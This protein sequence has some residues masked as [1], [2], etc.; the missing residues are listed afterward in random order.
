M[1]GAHAAGGGRHPG[2]VV[3]LAITLAMVPAATASM[4]CPSLSYVGIGPPSR[5]LS[6]RSRSYRSCS[7]AVR[8]IRR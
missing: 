5:M 1:T 8:S 2:R 4:R 7:N 6:G 3:R